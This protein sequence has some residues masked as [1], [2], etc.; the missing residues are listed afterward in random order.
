MTNGDELIMCFV[1][2]MSVHMCVCVCD[3]ACMRA[4]LCVCVRSP[5]IWAVWGAPMVWVRSSWYTTCC[6]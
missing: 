5:T 1:L 6:R 4:C 2:R 3:C